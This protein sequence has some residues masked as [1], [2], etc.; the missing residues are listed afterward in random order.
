MRNPALMLSHLFIETP[1]R[2][3][4]YFLWQGILIATLAAVVLVILKT[5][6]HLF[7]TSSTTW[8]QRKLNRRRAG[9]TQRHN[10]DWRA[11]TKPPLGFQR[12]ANGSQTLFALL[13]ATVCSMKRTPSR[14]SYT[15]G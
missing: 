11:V 15:F 14:P 5:R 2:S 6:Q 7:D 3:L 4:I 9:T 12:A 10:N 1:G 13:L 8:P